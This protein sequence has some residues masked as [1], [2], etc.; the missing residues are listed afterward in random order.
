MKYVGSVYTVNVHNIF[1][2]LAVGIFEVDNVR[3]GI[4]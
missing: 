4:G 3:Y 1:S 2:L